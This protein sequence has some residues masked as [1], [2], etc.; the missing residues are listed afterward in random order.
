MDVGGYLVSTVGG[1]WA[2]AG[3]DRD[4]LRVWPHWVEVCW[5]CSLWSMGYCA[6]LGFVGVAVGFY[7]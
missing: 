3:V 4:G 1:W 6:G 2:V 5:D 7:Y